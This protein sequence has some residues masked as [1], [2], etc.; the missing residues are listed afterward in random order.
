MMT[1]HGCHRTPLA[2]GQGGM[3]MIAHAEDQLVQ[4]PG[5]LDHI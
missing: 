2:V 1:Y 4:R 5:A 3:P